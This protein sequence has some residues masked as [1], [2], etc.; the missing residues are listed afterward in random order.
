MQPSSPSNSVASGSAGA[1]VGAGAGSKGK[2]L[3]VGVVAQL[4][5]GLN[6]VCA[7]YLMAN[8]STV[9]AVAPGPMQ[10]MVL[11]SLLSLLLRPSPSKPRVPAAAAAAGRAPSW[12]ARAGAAAAIGLLVTA[13]CLANNFAAARIPAYLGVMANMCAP[14]F[15]AVLEAAVNRRRPPRLLLPTIV[16][17]LAA[18]AAVVAGSWT[19]GAGGGLAALGAGGA[20][21]GLAL[22]LLAT[23]IMSVQMVAVQM[24][25]H[26]ITNQESMLANR[27][28]L[29][30]VCAPLAFLFEGGCSLAWLAG[31][32]PFAWGVLLFYGGVVFTGSTYLLPLAV[33]GLGA[34]APVATCISLRLVSSLA[35]Q[36]VLMPHEQPVTL[37]SLA[38]VAGVIL[39]VTGYLAVQAF[40]PDLAESS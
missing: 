20:V 18:S 26:L 19:G 13:Q 11:L 4:L 9:S 32:T 29:V 30:A 6:P 14:L 40:R 24:T 39:V 21:G 33:R 5:W 38:G 2:W 16:L 35:G 3:L 1:A 15:V 27:L 31:L 37:L 23:M 7:R 17:T 22:A 25:S 28:V 12:K 34:A 36:A 8:V 10:L